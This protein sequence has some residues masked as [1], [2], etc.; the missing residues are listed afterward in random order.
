[1]YLKI[2]NLYYKLVIDPNIIKNL[3]EKKA[4]HVLDNIQISLENAINSL[5]IN[6]Y[7]NNLSM[8]VDNI[9]YF[10]CNGC[11]NKCIFIDPRVNCA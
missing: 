10:Y 6:E 2:Q 9:K 7:K 3:I 11:N 1:M 5:T 4:K 8:V